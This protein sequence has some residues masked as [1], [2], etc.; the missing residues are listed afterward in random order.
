MILS[1]AAFFLVIS[2][3]KIGDIIRF[4]SINGMDCLGEII[5]VHPLYVRLIAKDESGN[6]TGR[7]I[8]IPNYK[9]FFEI[10]QKLDLSSQS[11]RRINLDII[12]HH[13]HF[14]VSFQEFMNRLEKFLEDHLSERTSKLAENFKSYFGLKY[15]IS[16]SYEGESIKV[17]LSYIQPATQT[18]KSRKAIIYFVES[19]RKKY[20]VTEEYIHLTTQD[21]PSSRGSHKDSATHKID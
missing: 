10:N 20:K 6:H 11:Y 21:T 15:K 3:Y 19:M 12:Y 17:A 14:D 13:A 5:Y 1:F 7:V 9:F 4:G 8:H 18:T 16:L 2:R